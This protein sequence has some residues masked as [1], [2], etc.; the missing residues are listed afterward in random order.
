MMRKLA[1]CLAI[2]SLVLCS[3]GLARAGLMGYWSFDDG[4]G[5]T[6]ADTSGRGNN[7]ILSGTSA[8]PAW[9]AGHS[10]QAGDYA[11]AFTG[12]AGNNSAAD[13][14]VQLGSPADL[15][16]GGNQTISMWLYPTNF[17]SGVRQ[18]PYAKA[19]SGSGTITQ[20]PGGALNYYRGPLGGNGAGFDSHGS[21]ALTLNAWN[22]ATIVRDFDAGEVRWYVNGRTTSEPTAFD[23]PG[24]ANPIGTGSLPAYFGRGYVQNYFGMIDNASIWN[25][26]LD[27]REVIALQ[28][29]VY[30]PLDLA[31]DVYL[32][33]V[34][35]YTYSA[36]PNADS[37]Y[38]KD[39]GKDGGSPTGDLTD[40]PFVFVGQSPTADDGTVGWSNG[41]SVDIT[42][43]LGG[44]RLLDQ[45]MVGYA[46]YTS[47][48]VGA[49][50]DVQIG[51]STDGVFDTEAFTT[52]SGFGGT[53]FRNELF[54]DVGG[55]RATHVMLRFDGGGTSSGKYVLDEVAF[56]A[57]PEPATLTLL[58]LGGLGLLARR[59]RKH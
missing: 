58:A 24:G 10:G 44:L 27:R 52:Y 3:A 39:E 29:D 42:F 17:D 28:H 57:V 48:G 55:E 59:R 7:G 51:L 43:D 22:F 33:N 21:P 47:W 19:Y 14:H 2:G 54:I 50:D 34:A 35:G 8:L 18:N 15:A 20:E 36:A 41:T 38:Y 56:F 25:E 23:P 49:P 46:Y 1:T 4:S 31:G 13:P 45:I 26:A 40:G 12:S 16:I 30:T 53:D 37:N 6:L 5:T 32:V 11:L 9:V